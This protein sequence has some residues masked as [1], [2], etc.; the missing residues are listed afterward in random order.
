MVQFGTPSAA[1]PEA[2]GDSD[3]V[4]VRTFNKES[5]FIRIAP[6]ERDYEGRHLVGTEA[7]VKELEHYDRLGFQRSFPCP[8]PYGFPKENCP[9]C[10]HPNEEVRKRS[11]KW[12]FNALDDKDYL[13]VFKIGVKLLRKFKL[14]EQRLGTLSDR[15]YE[16][17]RSGKDFNEI[18]YDLEA[19][20]KGDRKFPDTM[21]DIGEILSRNFQEA[22]DYYSGAAAKAK[23][24]S[25]DNDREEDAPLREGS[26]SSMAEKLEQDRA[27]RAKG[28]EEPAEEEAA[29]DE[30]KSWGKNPS[31][32]T[33]TGA[34]TS[35]I[36]A[37]LEDQKVEF[38]ARAPRSRIVALAKE[39][40]KKPP[41]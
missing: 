16:V 29:E 3:E 30:W 32:D 14:R 27:A 36:K 19:G 22:V 25:S 17:I 33:I 15:D 38:P 39:Q 26:N 34:E 28:Q 23:A 20:E 31:D 13:R 5:T 11:A 18:E 24:N 41:F 37:W 9:G 10:T 8:V 21:H 40:A 1:F 6:V 12:Y 7:W 2:G 4:W 35:D